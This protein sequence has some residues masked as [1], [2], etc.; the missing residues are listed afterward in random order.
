MKRA[1][2]K[3]PV[4][5]VLFSLSVL[6][7][8]PISAM[9][10]GDGAWTTPASP[11]YT[12]LIEEDL[13]NNEKHMAMTVLK[14]GYVG[15]ETYWGQASASKASTY[16]LKPLNDDFDMIA[17]WQFNSVTQATVTVESCTANC[18][19]QAGEV[20]TLNKFFGDM[21]ADIWIASRVP[22]TGQTGCWDANGTSIFC[23][24]TGQD[25]EY[26]LGVL[27]AVPPSTNP[28]TV[29]GWGGVRFTDNLDG[30]VTDN[31]TGLIWLKNANCFS[32]RTWTNALSDCNSLA[33]ETCSL[34]DGS[35]AGDW[36]L[37]NINELHSLVDPTQSNPALPVDYPF[38]NVL[39]SSY[40]S[41]T[42]YASNPYYAWFVYMS[43]GNVNYAN[44][45]Y[46]YYVWPV[47]SGN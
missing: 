24:G 22:E 6:L 12:F 13:V 27:P 43:Y 3:F 32:S 28:Y 14:P 38:A 1:M 20:V 16:L 30:T 25:G 21:K 29:Y 5:L 44:M 35:S 4:Y 47:R 11:G 18:L 19:W 23:T 26:Q 39:S 9:A 34:T 42:T 31:L 40:W 33:N 10:E 7:L 15:G 17:T 8:L 41:S 45:D 2:L 46:S 37:P 36:R